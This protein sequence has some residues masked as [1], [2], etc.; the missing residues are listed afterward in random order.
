VLYIT[1][2]S[3]DITWQRSCSNPHISKSLRARELQ[4]QALRTMEGRCNVRSQGAFTSA[5]SLTG[6]CALCSTA[7]RGL[8]R[9]PELAIPGSKTR[10]NLV[11]TLHTFPLTQVLCKIR[12]FLCINLHTEASPRS[13]ILLYV[14]LL[15]LVVFLSIYTEPSITIPL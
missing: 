4:L 5:S 6:C 1:T 8:L 7:A 14:F 2:L 11:R 3:P 13:V 10:V 12:V 9:P 15:F